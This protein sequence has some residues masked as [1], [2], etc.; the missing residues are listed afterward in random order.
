MI[1][2][3]ADIARDALFVHRPGIATRHVQPSGTETQARQSR[4]EQ[5]QEVRRSC[6]FLSRNTRTT[7]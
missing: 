2:A 4:K 3:R 1:L 5:Q 7:Y 6:D